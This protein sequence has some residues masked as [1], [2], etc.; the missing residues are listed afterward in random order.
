M[1]P[2][3][4][5]VGFGNVGIEIFMPAEVAGCMRRYKVAS[6]RLQVRR[7]SRRQVDDESKVSE[8]IRQLRSNTAC[9]CLTFRD[10]RY[11]FDVIR[12]RL[13]VDRQLEAACQWFASDS[14]QH[15][16]LTT[17]LDWNVVQKA[18]QPCGSS[19]VAER[20]EDIS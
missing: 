12:G 14:K 13:F 6:E 2:G 9:R 15:S 4:E 3:E 5:P 20:R 17:I 10:A 18:F 7:G 11:S 19:G 16:A 8:P 1:Y